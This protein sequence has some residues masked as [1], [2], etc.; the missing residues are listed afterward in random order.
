MS[1]QRTGFSP[2]FLPPPLPDNALL[3]LFFPRIR[4]HPT[5]HPPLP[6]SYPPPTHRRDLTEAIAL[7]CR[8]LAPGPQQDTEA[9]FIAAYTLY[10]LTAPRAPKAPA[11]L[12]D[13]QKAW[14]ATDPRLAAALMRMAASTH[15]PSADVAV[16]TLANL[17]SAPEAAEQARR[18]GMSFALCRPALR[19]PARCNKQPCGGCACM[20]AARA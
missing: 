9:A 4:F 11:V 17:A 15:R 12:T 3:D 18:L 8:A 2:R 7:L 6:V 16:E 1:T 20:Y 13:R 5:P 19:R 14:L 10:L